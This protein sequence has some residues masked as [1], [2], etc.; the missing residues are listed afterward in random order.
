MVKLKLAMAIAVA[1]VAGGVVAG[2]GLGI[3]KPDLTLL[4]PNIIAQAREA[5]QAAKAAVSQANSSE[6]LAWIR[7][8]ATAA[9]A[10]ATPTQEP[11]QQTS[12]RE[13]EPGKKHPL[14]DGNRTLIFVSWSMGAG[15]IKDIL[16]EL[17]GQPSVGIVFRGI[18]DGM[19]MA[20]AMLKMQ[21]LTTETQSSVGVLLD[22]TAFQRH[23]ITA[24]PSIAVETP[25]EKLLL[26]AAGLSSPSYLEDAAAEGKHGDLGVRGPTQEIL[27]RDLIEVAKERVAKLDTEAMK[28]HALERFWTQQPGFPLPGVTESARRTVDPSVIIPED[29]RAPN[30]TVIQ[31]AGRINPLDIMP[32]DQKLVVIDP[33]QAWQ[34]AL[35]K[36]E[37]AEHGGLTVT[38][39]APQIPA[40]SGWDLFNSVQDEFGGP[41]YLLPADMAERFQILRA[42]SVVTAQ[43]KSFIVREVSRSEFEGGSHAQK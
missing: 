18:P 35:A 10:Q 22:P 30:G 6:D 1:L 28:K 42:P 32:F 12:K 27:E 5:S 3:S 17:D 21:A 24:V 9:T 8:M 26:K 11:D 13:G 39:M 16:I 20:N 7:K 14:G 33:T 2:E 19:S 15:A 4:D 29:I 37:F 23:G 36:Q 38:V 31:R 34:V 43:G 41:L 40:S 25:E